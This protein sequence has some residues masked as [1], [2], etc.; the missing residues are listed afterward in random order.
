MAQWVVLSHNL[1]GVSQFAFFFSVLKRNYKFIHAAQFSNVMPWTTYIPVIW[2]YYTKIILNL[3]LYC[4]FTKHVRLLW[5]LQ[6]HAPNEYWHIK[7]DTFPWATLLRWQQ[8]CRAR[9]GH[10]CTTAGALS[11]NQSHGP[12]DV[13]HK[14][15]HSAVGATQ[16]GKLRGESR[17]ETALWGLFN[18]ISVPLFSLMHVKSRCDSQEISVT[19]GY[20]SQLQLWRCVRWLRCQNAKTNEK[21]V[22]V[23]EEL[24]TRERV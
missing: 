18:P 19:H 2:I 12:L 8:S 16:L 6:R 23:C 7:V 5:V 21:Q 14:T 1:F 10:D 15:T 11:G 24:W 22:T 20:P 13:L 4:S 17:A 3:L 9:S